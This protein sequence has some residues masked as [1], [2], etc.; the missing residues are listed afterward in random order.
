MFADRATSGANQGLILKMNEIDRKIFLGVCSHV[1]ESI[2]L[3]IRTYKA[4]DYEKNA[5][6]APLNERLTIALGS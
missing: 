1:T 6:R 5:I 4:Y 3:F 2:S